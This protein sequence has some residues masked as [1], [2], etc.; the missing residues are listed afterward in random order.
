MTKSLFD[1]L[2]ILPTDYDSY[3]GQVK[4]WED[5]DK[6]YPDCSCGCKFFLKLQGEFGNDWGICSNPKSP[7]KGLL[8]WEHMAGH[9]CFEVEDLKN[10][11]K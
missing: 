3:G 8:T 5:P 10:K 6:D 9:E 11:K 4:R 7:R 1:I 2:K